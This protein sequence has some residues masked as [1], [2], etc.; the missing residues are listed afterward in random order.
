MAIWLTVWPESSMGIAIGRS[1]W[2]KSTNAPSYGNF[3]MRRRGSRCPISRHHRSEVPVKIASYNIHKCR[4]A[5]G[6]VRPDRIIAVI[7]QIGADVIALQEVD[8]RFGNRGGLLDPV[9]IRR[10]T[11]LQLLVQVG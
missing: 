3:A 9:I 4:G 1:R 5:D 7:G 10:K 11:G 6:I 2:K 8:H